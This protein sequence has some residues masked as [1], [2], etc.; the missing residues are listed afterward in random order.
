M[1][2][3]NEPLTQRELEVVRLVATGLTNKEVAGNLFLSPS[4]VKVHLTNIFTK[5]NLHTRTELSMHAVRSGWLGP[6]TTP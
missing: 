5:L 3:L 2:E 1:V 4:T 6:L